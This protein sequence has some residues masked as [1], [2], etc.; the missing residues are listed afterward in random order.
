MDV[1]PSWQ[2]E[3]HVPSANETEDSEDAIKDNLADA[4]MEAISGDV[5]ASR[6]GGPNSARQGR[7]FYQ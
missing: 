3:D 1:Y 5:G 6:D 2:G 7:Y 4:M